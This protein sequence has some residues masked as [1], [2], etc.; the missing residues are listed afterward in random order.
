M[1]INEI[2]SHV[3]TKMNDTDELN[4]LKRVIDM[5]REDIARGLKNSLLPGDRVKVDSQKVGYGHIVKVNR[6]KVVVRD[7]NNQQWTVPLTMI[8]TKYLEHKVR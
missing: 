8:S 4:H 6:T 5:R 3:M 1:E 2:V 7:D